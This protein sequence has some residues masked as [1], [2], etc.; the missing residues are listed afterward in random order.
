MRARDGFHCVEVLA[1]VFECVFRGHEAVYVVFGV[2]HDFAQQHVLQRGGG[3]GRL[4]LRV[5]AFHCFDEVGEGGVEV[6][7][8]GVELTALHV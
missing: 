5:V 6:A 1:G 4:V 7:V 8:F 3:F 2:Y